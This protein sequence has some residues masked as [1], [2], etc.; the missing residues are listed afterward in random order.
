MYKY[1]IINKKG[2]QEIL[3]KISIDNLINIEYDDDVI[4]YGTE[5]V[6]IFHV[7]CLL[8]DF[9]GNENNVKVY[10]KIKNKKYNMPVISLHE[11]EH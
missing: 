7:D 2:A 1:R 4:Q 9:H 10:I 3:K 11:C 6:V 8:K 5:E